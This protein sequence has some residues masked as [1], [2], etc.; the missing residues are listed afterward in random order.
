MAQKKNSVMLSS[1]WTCP[2]CNTRN[3]RTSASARSAG[4]AQPA[5][6]KFEQAPRKRSSPTRPRSL[7][8]RPDRTSTAPTAAPAIPARPQ[9]ASSAAR[10]AEGKAREAGDVLGGLKTEPAAPIKC[11]S[12]G[13]ENPAMAHTCAKCGAPLAKAAPPPPSPHPLPRTRLRE[14]AHIHRRGDSDR[15][16]IAFI[17]MGSRSK[18]GWSA[19]SPT[20]TGGGPS[21][22]KRSCEYARENWR[23]EIPADAEIGSCRKEVRRTQSARARHHASVRHTLCQGPGHWLR[24]GDPGLPVPD[25]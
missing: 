21:P 1:E 6:V 24:Q 20:S 23:T 19:R 25:L 2:A 16:I 17:V 11:P 5:E 12:C 3:P 4:A 10:L 14:S 18:K 22:S 8:P 15:E 7:R 13:A 9:P